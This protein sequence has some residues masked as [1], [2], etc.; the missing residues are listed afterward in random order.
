[1]LKALAHFIIIALVFSG[2]WFLLSKIDFV[3]YFQVEQLTKSNERKLGEW[4]LEAAKQ[5][6]PEIASDS[7]QTFVD[8]IQHRLCAANGISD[9]TIKLHILMRDDI[10]AFALPNRHL[11][12]YTGLISYCNSPEEL[13]GVL[14]HEIAH[15]EHG[16]VMKKLMK[17]VGLAML[18]TIAGGNAGGEI[19]REMVRLLSSSAFDREQ[20]R[21]ADNSAVHMMAKADI[22]PEPLANLFFRLSREK[23]SL[24]KH[25][26]LLSTHPDS[27]DRASEILKL[28]KQETY[29]S[30]PI[31]D[32]TVWINMKRIVHESHQN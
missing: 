28:R 31:A 32:S 1:M 18:M 30:R 4:I 11:I 25:F 2:T 20:E 9:S 7:V 29:H 10:N 16:H 15:M 17:E 19:G 26:E 6:R 14:A 21:E 12:V 24:P 3:N 13:A 22:D 23:N 27:Q 8:G 5:G